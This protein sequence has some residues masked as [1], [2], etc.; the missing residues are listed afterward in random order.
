MAERG[1]EA[2]FT[3]EPR[4]ALRIGQQLRRED[5]D[6][7]ITLQLGVASAVYDAHS[8]GTDQGDDAILAD[9]LADHGARRILQH[10]QECA[11]ASSIVA[12]WTS[13]V[14]CTRRA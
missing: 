12:Q 14:S 13:T 4:A 7:D 6:R 1:Q 9:L 11:I 5:L 2:R 8:A 3:L 10:G